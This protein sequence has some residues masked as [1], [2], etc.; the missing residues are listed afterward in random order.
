MHPDNLS[1]AS[2]RPHSPPTWRFTGRQA[3][4]K[5]K[6]SR[7]LH[8]R[9]GLPWHSL[10]ILLEIAS[11]SRG[12]RSTTDPLLALIVFNV[13]ST[14]VEVLRFR[15]SAGPTARSRLHGVEVY[16]SR[17]ALSENMYSRLHEGGGHP[18]GRA[19]SRWLVMPSSRAWR[20]ASLDPVVSTE[21]EVFRCDSA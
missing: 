19:R 12:W 15:S 20:S 1:V 18:A 10:D 8:R 13:V 3:G 11:S 21:V 5:L 16:L 6:G 17:T 7:S 4:N 2:D 9:G 14:E